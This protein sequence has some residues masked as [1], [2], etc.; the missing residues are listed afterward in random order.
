MDAFA[1]M[2]FLVPDVSGPADSVAPGS[3]YIPNLRMQVTLE[4]VGPV[5]VMV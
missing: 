1:W 5:S 4:M 3:S 2:S